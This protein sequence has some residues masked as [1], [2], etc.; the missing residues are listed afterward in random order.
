MSYGKALEAAGAELHEFEQF[1]SYQGDWWALVT[2]NGTKGF[3]HGSYGSCS[4]C[5]AFEGEFGYGAEDECEEHRYHG[6]KADCATCVSTK[7]EYAKRLK[8][9]GIGYL[10]DVLSQEA[11]IKEASRHLDWD[12]EAEGM[13]AWIKAQQCEGGS[14]L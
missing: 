4:V 2:Y 9:F 3:V 14:R 5:D 8:D 12:S 10:D 1:G 7:T 13:V 6:H 11:A